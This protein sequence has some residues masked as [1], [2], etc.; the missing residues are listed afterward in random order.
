MWPSGFIMQRMVGHCYVKIEIKTNV[1]F[2]LL[3]TRN[4]TSIRAPAMQAVMKQAN[5]AE[6][7]AL[8]AYFE[9]SALLD[10]AKV[11]NPEIWM[12]IDAG[13]ENPHRAKVAIVFDLCD[14][15]PLISLKSL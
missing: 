11:L 12:P 9:K 3:A 7:N 1:R 2:T 10:G 8:M 14:I 13:L 4:Q 15:C 5:D 6:Q